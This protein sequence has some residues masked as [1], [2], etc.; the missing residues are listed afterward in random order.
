MMLI[1]CLLLLTHALPGLA[2]ADPEALGIDWLRLSM[3]LF[4]GLA[5]FLFGMEQMS[6]GLKA[7]ARPQG[8]PRALDQE[9]F[10]GR[11]HRRLCHSGVEF[12]VGNNGAGGGFHLRRVH[13]MVYHCPIQQTHGDQWN[14]T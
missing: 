10:P 2:Q 4:G 5:M 12:L 11:G 1:G 14:A 6:E 8:H 7:A 3:G 9:P 13:A